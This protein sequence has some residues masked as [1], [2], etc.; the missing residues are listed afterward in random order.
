MSTIASWLGR[1]YLKRGHREH[2]LT[3]TRTH[4]TTL[5]HTHNPPPH[6]HTQLMHAYVC[7]HTT[8]AHVCTHTHTTY[9]HTHT[10][11]HTHTHSGY[12]TQHEF[13]GLKTLTQYQYR[14]R[15][16]NEAGTS[17]WSPVVLVATTSESCTVTHT[18]HQQ[19]N[20]AII[21]SL[22]PRPSLTTFFTA[23]DFFFP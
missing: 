13:T 1:L 10:H 7:S 19:L 14:L 11:A 2:T 9:T 20:T 3:H 12:S 4:H 15:A 16:T 17:P 18:A 22:V 5:S 8:H 21:P 23:M 6:T